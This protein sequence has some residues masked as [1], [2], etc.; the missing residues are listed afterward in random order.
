MP[1]YS[2][3]VRDDGAYNR[4]IP[5]AI[6]KLFT[7]DGV[8]LVDTAETGADGQFTVTAPD[9]QYTLQVSYGG[10]SERSTVLVGNPPEYVGAAGPADAYRLSLAIFKAASITDG[11]SDFDGSTW[12]WTLS[13]FSATAADQIDVNV[14]EANSTPLTVGAWVRQRAGGVIYAAAAAGSKPRT[15]ENK[16]SEDAISILDFMTYAEYLDTRGSVNP[17]MDVAPAINA[18]EAAARLNNKSVYMPDGRYGIGQRVNYGTNNPV[19]QSN[20]PRGLIGQSKTGATF[21][22]LPSLTG[23]LLRSWS[24]AGNE[25][26]SFGIDTS[27]STAQAWDARWLPNDP[28]RS[29]PSTQNTIRDI[30]VTGT[31]NLAQLPN[32]SPVTPQVNFDDLNDTYPTNFTVRIVDPTHKTCALSF[33]GSGGLMGLVGTIWTGGYL[34]WGCQNGSMLHS[35][36][37]GIE[38][39]YGCLNITTLIAPYP[40]DNATRK[41]CYWSEQTPAGQT[42]TKHL[43]IIGGQIG[44]LHADSVY[45]DMVLYSG[46]DCIGCEFIG[47]ATTLLGPNTRA[48]SFTTAQ[49]H[50][51]GGHLTGPT[52]FN[53][54][55]GVVVTT[56]PH[57]INDTTGLPLGKAWRG[58]FTPTLLGGST[59]GGTFVNTSY[60]RWLRQGDVVYYQMR[61]VWTAHPAA[62]QA[63]T[64]IGLPFNADGQSIGNVSFEFH[65]D[66]FP[67]NVGA[68]I[69]GGAVAFYTTDAAAFPLPATG[70]IILSGSYTVQS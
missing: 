49:V 69:G 30:I 17:T 56:S 53:D 24:L 31:A 33:V 57:F 10:A 12:Y 48:D 41:A 61:L 22:A 62:G 59:A 13:D 60:G 39:A 44:T 63:A 26:A 47:P 58:V 14:V 55:A 32:Q 5:G 23:T 43:T 34:R 67:F 15:M 36:G 65:G 8:T 66:T 45:F 7:S 11:K 68:T 25:F 51:E 16:L 6:V 70:N 46:I 52:V 4:P 35:W 37:T 1:D 20:A 27:D 64:I 28:N 9:G 50:M 40:F 19:A 2:D 29:G 18:C 21:Y 3:F 38:F 42:S 54:V